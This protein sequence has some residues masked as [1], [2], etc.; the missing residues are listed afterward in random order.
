MYLQMYLRIKVYICIYIYIYVNGKLCFDEIDGCM[1][2]SLSPFISIH[3]ILK[4]PA[5]YTTVTFCIALCICPHCVCV[6]GMY[7]MV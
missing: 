7:S 3:I 2:V 6:C 4:C 1:T 5:V